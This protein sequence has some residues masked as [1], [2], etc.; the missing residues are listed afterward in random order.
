MKV[1]LYARVSTT[2]QNC[3]MQ[4]REL[5]TYAKARGWI[6]DNEFVD[7]GWSGN[8]SSRPEFDSM[9]RRAARRDFDAVL[10]WKL[11]R[12]GRS[13][14][15][16]LNGIA[17]LDSHGVRFVATS[18]S[19]DTDKQNPSARFLL[20]ILLAV[21]EFERE[22]T[23]ERVAAG[24]ARYREDF[25]KGTAKSRSGKNLPVGRPKKVFRRDEAISLRR[26]GCSFRFIAALLKI[27]LATIVA[28]CKEAS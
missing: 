24:S 26:Q 28:A 23:R 27:P 15:N 20:V 7:T 6:I 5:R 9:M 14:A 17:T 16:C 10:V 2:D 12:F 18:Q 11:D 13:V 8:K 1:A 4:L 25:V 19:I 21:A 22:L 3:E